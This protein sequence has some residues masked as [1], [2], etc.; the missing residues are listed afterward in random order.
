V[1]RC[2]EEK[3]INT[4]GMSSSSSYSFSSSILLA[5]GFTNAIFF[6]YENDNEDDL[7]TEYR[8]AR[9]PFRNYFCDN[10]RS[11]I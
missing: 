5:A 8:G 3:V 10:R 7:N 9:W 11:F 2:Q 4:A 1:F 6:D